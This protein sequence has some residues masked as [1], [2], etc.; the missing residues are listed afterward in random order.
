MGGN[1]ANL[2]MKMQQMPL[3]NQWSNRFIETMSQGKKTVCD[4]F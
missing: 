1:L 2:A 4:I 3:E